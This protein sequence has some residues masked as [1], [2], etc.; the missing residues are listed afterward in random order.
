MYVHKL[1]NFFNLLPQISIK[2]GENYT[3]LLFM[4]PVYQQTFYKTEPWECCT[5]SLGKIITATTMYI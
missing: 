4:Y 2:M 5:L 3:T 1:Y